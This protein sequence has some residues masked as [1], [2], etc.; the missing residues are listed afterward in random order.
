MGISQQLGCSC[1]D[2]WADIGSSL[3]AKGTLGVYKHIM[4]ER[5]AHNV[6]HI[7]VSVR[8][9][10]YS[11]L[12]CPAVMPMQV[13]HIHAR[14]GTKQ[15]GAPCVTAQNTSGRNGSATQ[16]TPHS[17][18]HPTC[19]P[20]AHVGLDAAHIPR[21]KR[22]SAAAGVRRCQATAADQVLHQL[23]PLQLLWQTIQPASTTFDG[24][25]AVV[26]LTDPGAVGPTAAAAAGVV[27]MEGV[28]PDVP[29]EG[30][31][32]CRGCCDGGVRRGCQ[33]GQLL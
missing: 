2:A 9:V 11:T 14:H 21:P 27:D 23:Q 6:Q 22:G 7:A 1:L 20:L 29:L 4:I 15:R 12:H 17:T 8:C 25:A 33:A 24:T 19:T 28:A 26:D 5:T 32:C 18:V 10:C 16:H 3:T 31:G 30:R 13:G